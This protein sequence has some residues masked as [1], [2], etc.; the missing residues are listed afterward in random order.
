MLLVPPLVVFAVALAVMLVLRHVALRLLRRR[1]T[2]A[3]SSA[4]V[5][6]DT[7]SLPSV[8]WAVAIALEFALANAELPSKWVSKTGDWIGAFIIVSLTLVALSASV[9]MM[10][11]YGERQGMPFAAAGLSRTLIRVVVVALGLM[12]LLENFHIPITPLV[13]ALGVGGIAVALAL[14]DTLANFFAGI[15]ILVERP[16]F[17]GDLIRLENGQEGVVS[18]IGWRTTRV[19]TGGNDTVVVPNTKI[20]SGIL[21][22]YNLPDRRAVVEVAIL[23]SHHA[24]PGQVCRIAVEEAA[25]A[26]GVLE[27]P[28][29]LCLFDPGVLPTHSQFKLLVN[30]ASRA[31]QG[32][33]ASDIRMQLLRRFRA[34]GV[35]LPDPEAVRAERR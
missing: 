16:I 8:L 27:N 30:V 20:T 6:A 10:T 31:E 15:H 35:P 24:D 13:T 19:R 33:V 23:V 26:E 18:D 29:P 14:Q 11:V 34:E 3:N 5:L 17:V 9:R 1:A 25:L 32:R 2:G 22:N 7:L 28:A 12:A 21:V 4:S